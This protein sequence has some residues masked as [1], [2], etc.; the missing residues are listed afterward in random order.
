MQYAE[1]KPGRI[2]YIRIEHGEELHAILMTF[3]TKNN[4]RSGMVHI[5]GGVR[6]TGIVS[7]PK[8]DK[9]P[10]EPDFHEIPLAHEIIGTGII[11]QGPDGPAMHLHIAAGRGDGSRVGC[12]RGT[13]DV[14]LVIEV[15]ITEFI[16]I[17]LPMAFDPKTGL[18][19]PVPE[20]I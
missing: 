13:A 16:G 5:I 17:A 18:S 9:V 10:S 2:F 15:I 6:N 4:I 20:T 3:I 7:G 1:G 8:E 14:F 19:L 11:R 12:L